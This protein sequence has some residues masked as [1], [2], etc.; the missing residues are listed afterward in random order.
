MLGLQH[1][2]KIKRRMLKRQ[3]ICKIASAQCADQ[4][5]DTK[6]IGILSDYDPNQA[7]QDRS[8]LSPETNTYV[9]TPSTVV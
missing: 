5:K 7:K 8:L 4:E 6:L 1:G 3:K 2:S 9:S